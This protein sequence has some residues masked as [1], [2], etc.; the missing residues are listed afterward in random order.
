MLQKKL[1][2]IKVKLY[3]KIS[4]MVGLCVGAV[5]LIGGTIAA[6]GDK[7]LN[8]K[9]SDKLRKRYMNIIEIFC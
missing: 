5:G 7:I 2:L 9:I 3:Y 1:T 6:F 8:E 4:Y